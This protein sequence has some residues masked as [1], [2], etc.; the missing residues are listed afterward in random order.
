MMIV[1]IVMR[2]W[3]VQMLQEGVQPRIIVDDLLILAVDG[4][5]D[6]STFRVTGSGDISL[7]QNHLY[8]LRKK[9][10]ILSTSI[11]KT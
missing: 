1:A 2:P 10:L 8:K 3:V 6:C 4:K 9:L 7:E 5:E 11:C